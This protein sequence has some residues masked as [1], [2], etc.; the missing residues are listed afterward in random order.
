MMGARGRHVNSP[1]YRTNR[2]L[3]YM[4]TGVIA[5]IATLTL[6][7]PHPLVGVTVGAYAFAAFTWLMFEL[8][9][10]RLRK[11]S[12]RLRG[13]LE[14][15]AKADLD[16]P[17]PVLDVATEAFVERAWASRFARSMSVSE[18]VP[19]WVD[20]TWQ[21][22]PIAYGTAVVVSRNMF[23]SP[24][25]FVCVD[26]EGATELFSVVH[27]SMLSSV[28]R[29]GKPHHPVKIGDAAIDKSWHIDTDEA[30]AKHVF[31]D[32][33][34]RILGELHARVGSG[35]ASIELTRAGLVVRW[36]SELTA[37]SAA[38]LRTLAL[39]VRDRI[40][41]HIA[42]KARTGVRVGGFRAAGDVEEV[43]GEASADVNAARAE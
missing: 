4:L 36:P 5:L 42:R 10:R 8:H 30:L 37:G 12:Q 38:Y 34:R 16:T 6:F 40:L 22:K 3:K 39:H 17:T 21:G 28:V 24:H 11:V 14:A 7:V 43:A 32:E 13:E 19:M 41:E 35:V 15:I 27:D 31:D 33:T 2:T 26:A 23:E 1:A 9:A 20:G 18:C 25:S 29:A